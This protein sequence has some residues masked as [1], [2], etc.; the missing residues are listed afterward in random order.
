MFEMSNFWKHH[1][2]LYFG[3]LLR[4]IRLEKLCSGNYVGIS[5]DDQLAA[6]ERNIRRGGFETF[7]NN[8]LRQ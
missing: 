1:A 7:R 8:T 4:S 2:V 6:G 5:D 3:I